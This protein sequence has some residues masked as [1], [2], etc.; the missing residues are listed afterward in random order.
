[1]AGFAPY[2]CVDRTMRTFPRTCC[3]VSCAGE[4]AAEDGAGAPPSEQESGRSTCVL[5]QTLSSPGLL[6][7][8]VRMW[9]R[10][11]DGRAPS[12]TGCGLQGDTFG[13]E[14]R[15]W[16]LS[17]CSGWPD[18]AWAGC[19]QCDGTLR[20]GAGDNGSS[21]WP[22]FLHHGSFLLRHSSMLLDCSHGR[23]VFLT[24]QRSRELAPS[25]GVFMQ[26]RKRRSQQTPAETGA[27]RAPVSVVMFC[28]HGKP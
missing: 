15:G 26:E 25:S 11:G 19:F 20:F 14:C 6:F 27:S 3:L 17:T 13:R 5:G 4:A 21:F 10:K 16:L 28:A 8:V 2:V 7:S 22:T 23:C 1:M 12:P 9:D 18:S 24:T